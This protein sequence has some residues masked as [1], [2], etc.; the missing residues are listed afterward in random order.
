VRVQQGCSACQ[1]ANNTLIPRFTNC[2]LQALLTSRPTVAI[3]VG[4]HNGPGGQGTSAR[5]VTPHAGAQIT[6]SP[7]LP[8]I[9]FLIALVAQPFLIYHATERDR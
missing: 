1:H 8:R 6:N 9:D 3:G 5:Y 4:G 7:I 2:T